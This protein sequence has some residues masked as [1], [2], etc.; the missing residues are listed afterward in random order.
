MVVSC[1]VLEQLTLVESGACSLHILLKTLRKPAE[2]RLGARK[3]V[4][5]LDSPRQCGS[6][7]SKEMREGEGEGG[8]AMEA[9]VKSSRDVVRGRQSRLEDS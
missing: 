2:R 4:K 6:R 5:S 3:E 9:G 7:G 8:G 1:Y